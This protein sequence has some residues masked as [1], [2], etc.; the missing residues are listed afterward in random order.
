[1]VVVDIFKGGSVMAL[2]ALL[3]VRVIHELHVLLFH[4]ER[5]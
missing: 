1:M 3:I 4:V 5:I 2:S